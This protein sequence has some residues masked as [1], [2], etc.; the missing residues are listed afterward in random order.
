M[1]PPL[2]R[3]LFVPLLRQA[4]KV[5]PREE[6]LQDEP[7]LAEREGEQRHEE[8]VRVRAVL[9]HEAL[10]SGHAAV[11][12]GVVPADLAG[13]NLHQSLVLWNEKN[14]G[15]APRTGIGDETATLAKQDRGGTPR[16][17]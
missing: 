7:R 1:L 4:C 13:H 3:L 11:R 16:F 9:R 10:P 5:T 14:R 12:V 6:Q 17:V 8:H 15:D 2:R